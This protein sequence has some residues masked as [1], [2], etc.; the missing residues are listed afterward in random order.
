[1]MYFDIAISCFVF[2]IEL[3]LCIVYRYSDE[4]RCRPKHVKLNYENQ[5]R[6]S[7]C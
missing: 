5:K 6:S 1:M 2:P 4:G 7:F 3:H